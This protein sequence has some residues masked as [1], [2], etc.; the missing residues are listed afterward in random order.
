M[1]AFST[2]QFDSWA[3]REGLTELVLAQAVREITN[4]LLGDNLGGYVYKKRIKLPGRGKSG[5]ART[6]IAYRANEKVFFTFGFAKNEREN[7][8]SNELKAIKALAAE[9]LA[10]TNDQLEDAIEA[11]A[12]KEIKGGGTE[13]D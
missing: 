4:G 9:L 7:I 3:K 11:G 6:L 12:L 8:D 10:Y 13:N 5:G 1:R 2:K